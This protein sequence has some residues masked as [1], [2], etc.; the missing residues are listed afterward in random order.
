MS[1]M[2]RTPEW[3]NTDSDKSMSIAGMIIKRNQDYEQKVDFKMWYF[4]DI[5]KIK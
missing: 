1:T 4:L 2:N 3:L 5:W